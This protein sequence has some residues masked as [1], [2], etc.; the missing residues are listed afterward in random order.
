[1]SNE[2][3][4]NV[5][6]ADRVSGTISDFNYQYTSKNVQ[7]GSKYLVG[8]KKLEF[9]AGCIYQIN[10]N[11]NEFKYGIAGTNFTFTATPGNYSAS[12]LIA[13][14]QAHINASISSIPITN[15][16]ITLS[17]SVPLNKIGFVKA[18][19]NA[20]STTVIIRGLSETLGCS[21]AVILGNGNNDITLTTSVIYGPNQVDMSPYDYI[22]LRCNQ[23]YSN[24]F[25]NSTANASDILYRI[26]LA[27]D[28]NNKLYLNEDDFKNNL[29]EVP[30]LSSNWRFSITDRNGNIIDLSGIDY[31][32]QLRLIKI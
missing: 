28:R 12:E 24:S 5:D 20:P 1:M 11:N 16:T 21:M 23:V 26:Q 30:K 6:S 25:T 3:Y 10:S 13:L 2:F 17:Y 18:G 32:F 19:S 14:I 27:V 29:I 7:L 9:P 8:L 31:S 15:L 22:F 4:V